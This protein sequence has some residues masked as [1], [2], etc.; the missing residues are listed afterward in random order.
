MELGDPDAR[1]LRVEISHSPISSM[2]VYHQ[3]FGCEVLFDQEH[4]AALISACVKVKSPATAL[5]APAA[6]VRFRITSSVGPEPP[7]PWLANAS[8]PFWQCSSFL[9]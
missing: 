6:S 4:G 5:K 8:F 7:I 3:Y 2:K 1:P 9:V